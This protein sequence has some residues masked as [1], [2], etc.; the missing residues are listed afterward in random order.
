MGDP[1]LVD[2][3]ARVMWWSSMIGVVSH[4]VCGRGD[5]VRGDI[6]Q[7]TGDQSSDSTTPRVDL[8]VFVFLP[9][10]T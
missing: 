6:P 9:I 4:C 1:E 2:I 7:C 5:E 3:P 10:V 8:N